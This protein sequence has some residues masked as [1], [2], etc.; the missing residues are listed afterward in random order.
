MVKAKMKHGNTTEKTATTRNN[1]LP[2]MYAG[3]N[4]CCFIWKEYLRCLFTK[5]KD[6]ISAFTVTE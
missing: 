2:L 6:L 3:L 5:N 4:L 1:V